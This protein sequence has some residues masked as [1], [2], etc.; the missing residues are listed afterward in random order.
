[1]STQRRIKTCYSFYTFKCAYYNIRRLWLSMLL[2]IV[3]NKMTIT[4]IEKIQIKSAK[5]GVLINSL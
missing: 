2:M 4:M 3:F 5:I 1:M